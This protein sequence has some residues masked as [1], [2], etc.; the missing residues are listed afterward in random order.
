[1]IFCHA[2]AEKMGERIFLIWRAQGGWTRRRSPRGPE[3]GE[4][5]KFVG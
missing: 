5:R 4:S 1:M 3:R 2:C